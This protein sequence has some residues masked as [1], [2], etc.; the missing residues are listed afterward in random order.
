MTIH[1]HNKL[2]AVLFIVMVSGL[3]FAKE[4]YRAEGIMQIFIIFISITYL[5]IGIFNYIRG[6]MSVDGDLENKFAAFYYCLWLV[7]LISG[8]LFLIYKFLSLL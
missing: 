4:I 1:Q 7:I 6:L 3:F 5:I 2:I 8:L